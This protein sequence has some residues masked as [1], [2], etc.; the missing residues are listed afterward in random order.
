MFD[1]FLHG[2]IDFFFSGESPDAKPCG[3]NNRIYITG[4]V[5]KQFDNLSSIIV[6]FIRD[7]KDRYLNEV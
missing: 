6:F 5:Y 7:L 2:V 4:A 1:G 3:N